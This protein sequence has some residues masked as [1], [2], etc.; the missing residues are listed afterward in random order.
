MKIVISIDKQG[1]GQKFRSEMFY[2]GE[3][4]AGEGQTERSA[5]ADMMMAFGIQNEIDEVLSD[6]SDSDDNYLDSFFD[7]SGSNSFDRD[8][9]ISG[10]M[11]FGYGNI[12]FQ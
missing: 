8:I 7:K 9:G 10:D 12:K 2:R 11:D 5:I 3:L 4:F 6:L 1:N